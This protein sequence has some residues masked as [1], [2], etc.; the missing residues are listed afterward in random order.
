MICTTLSTASPVPG[1]RSITIASSSPHSDC[2]ANCLI[3]LVTIGPRQISGW[4]SSTS[5]PIDI[6]L[7][8]SIVGGTIFS[9]GVTDGKTFSPIRIAAL[10]P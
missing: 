3:A 1:G 9:S 10:G 8:P 4:S 7:I 5:M 2:S 6:T